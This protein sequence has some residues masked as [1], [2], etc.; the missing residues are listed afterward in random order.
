MAKKQVTRTV[1]DY[2]DCEMETMFTCSACGMD[3]CSSHSLQCGKARICQTCWGDAFPAV[4]FV[5]HNDIGL[6]LLGGGF[7]PLSSFLGNH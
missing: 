7:G 5:H 3:I 1:C 2:L 4:E 6:P